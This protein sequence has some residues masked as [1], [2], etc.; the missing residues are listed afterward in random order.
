MKY[1]VLL[2]QSNNTRTM[3]LTTLDLISTDQM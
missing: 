2:L 1:Q 3:I